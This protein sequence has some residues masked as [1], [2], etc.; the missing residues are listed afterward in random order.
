M[1]VGLNGLNEVIS[2]AAQSQLG[3]VQLRTGEIA[4]C[5]M[6][7]DGLGKDVRFGDAG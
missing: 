7:D 2:G 1:L 5:A 4:I 3:S 6:V